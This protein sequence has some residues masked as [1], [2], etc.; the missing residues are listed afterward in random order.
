MS[1]APGRSHTRSAAQRPR[2]HTTISPAPPRQQS[3][4]NST[5]SAVQTNGVAPGDH[6]EFGR[7]I[8]DEST[9]S[10][11][12]HVCGRAFQSLGAHV[13]VH[14]MTAA[15]YRNEFG[16]LRSRALSARSLSHTQSRAAGSR[17]HT[18]REAQER[19]AAGRSMAR[20]GEL[21]RRRWPGAR[22][23]DEPD[24]LRRVRQDSLTAG[25]R[26]QAEAADQR[27]AAAL[28]AGAFTDL[29][30]ALR[31][32]YIEE[33]NSIEET[34]RRISVGKSRL[35]DLLIAH[36]IPLRPSGQNSPAGRRSRIVLN[37]RAAAERVGAHDIR[38]WLRE[39]KAAGA[40]LRELSDATGRSMPW[41]A[42]RL[43][44]G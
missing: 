30:Q 25:R 14:G 42:T 43:R 12:C 15:E 21:N 41:V 9:D 29:G 44:R 1:E 40:T 13:R 32:L 2:G 27:V 39:R 23:L 31:I 6:P 38:E 33:R 37:E 4:D 22:E 17:Y 34:A 19:F 8:R 26:V 28:R 3:D 20:S 7:L 10:V 16:L 36:N 11:I 35:R 5:I 24:E 18:S